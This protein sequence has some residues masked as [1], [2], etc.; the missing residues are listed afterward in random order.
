M[1][2]AISRSTIKKSAKETVLAFIKALNKE[3]FASGRKYIRDD[4]K[5]IGV[6]GIRDGGDVY[7][8]DMTK[9]KMKYKINKTFENGNDVCLYYELTMSGQNIPGFGL[10]H[11]K[12]GKIETITAI[13][14][15]RPVLEQKK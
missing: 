10:Y 12:G 1:A 4:M 3:D 5:F 11:L 14:D 2:K 7:I 13:F 6:L 8:Q 9:M 15:P